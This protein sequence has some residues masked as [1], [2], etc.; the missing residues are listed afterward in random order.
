[1]GISGCGKTTLGKGLAA[2]TGYRFIEGDDLHPA[3]NIA[4][5][6]AG[7]AL[8]DEDRWPW[9]ERVADELRTAKE[10]DGRIVSCSA[11]RHVYRNLLNTRSSRQLL[12]V[13]PQLPVDI[14]RARLRSRPDHYMPASLIDSQ[15]ATLEL[16]R[17]GE[18]VLTIDGAAE[19]SRCVDLVMGFL[20]LREMPPRQAMTAN[21]ARMSTDTSTH[22]GA[23]GLDVS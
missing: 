6:S 20:S 18:N 1:M 4:K 9:L 8:T 11:L 15:M 12:F 23:A 3:E 5:M 22:R 13:F 19:P 2:A 16:P 7:I 14:V 10:G 17:P 21:Q